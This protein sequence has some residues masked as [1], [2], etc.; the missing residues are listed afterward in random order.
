M[1]ARR[2]E[3]TTVRTVLIILGVVGG[4][5]LLI[6]LTCAGIVYYWT[7]S[8]TGLVSSVAK[9]VTDM[10][11]AHQVGESFLADLG[12]GRIDVAY[13]A[14]TADFRKG[15]TKEQLRQYVDGFPLLKQPTT[16]WLTLTQTAGTLVTFEVSLTGQKPGEALH[17]S[18]RLA[19]EGDTWKVDHFSLQP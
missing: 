10:Q 1:H 7:R 17:G 15:Q 12:Q 16:R 8:V 6:V 3:D 13:A 18:I 4:I 19:K 9:T 2:E 14:T 11:A 5:V